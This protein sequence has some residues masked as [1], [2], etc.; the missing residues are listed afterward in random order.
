M[1]PLK[2]IVFT[3]DAI[4]ALVIVGLAV[5]ILAYFNYS[6]QSPYSAGPSVTN[7]TISALS[8]E[9]PATLASADNV[10][11]SI[12]D[13]YNASGE[14]WMQFMGGTSRSAYVAQGPL[15]PTIQYIFSANAP[16]S[17]SILAGYGNIYF[18]AGNTLYAVNASSGTLSWSNTLAYSP[19]GLGL[20]DGMLVYGTTSNTA[21]LSAGNGTAL[22]SSSTPSSKTL[23]YDNKIYTILSGS[24]TESTLDANNGTLSGSTSL[25][26]SAN[27]IL[28][29][30]GSVY[31]WLSSN[32]IVA[33]NQQGG[34]VITSPY[35]SANTN[36]S[37]SDGLLYVGSNAF[38]CAFYLNLTQ[39]FC[40]QMPNAITAVASGGGVAAYENSSG[41]SLLSQS[42]SILWNKKMSS[43]GTS[44]QY[45]IVTNSSVYSVWSNGYVIR[46]NLST[47]AV[48]WSTKLPYQYGQI[49]R[50][51][52]GYGN[53]YVAASGN[54]IAY[55]ACSSQPYSSILQNI[56][57]LYF[58]GRGSCA[59]YLVDK[60][61]SKSNLGVFIN[62]SYAPSF[63]T[64]IFNGA[65]S[66]VNMSTSNMPTGSSSI[67]ASG[68]IYYN[69]P[70]SYD[71]WEAIYLMGSYSQ[72][73]EAGMQIS[74]TNGNV[75]IFDS[76][77]SC[78]FTSS[79]QVPL[80]TWSFVGFSHTGGTTTATLY[81]NGQSQ[82]GS[83]GGCDPNIGSVFNMIGAEPNQH[84]R[85]FFGNIANIQVYSSA[86]NSTQMNELYD[87]GISGGPVSS[88]VVG[89]WPL[90][91]DTND[92]SGYNNTG[93]PIN[94]NYANGN[95]IPQSYQGAS[96][97]SVSSALVPFNRNGGFNGANSL[98]SNNPKLYKVSVYSWK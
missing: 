77:G 66:Y 60:I 74:D 86:L 43:Y 30:N 89:W 35:P 51:S 32:N 56:V 57:Q 36:I 55:G 92:Y 44:L 19:S 72:G 79:L 75:L 67:S 3:T 16:V 31:A 34:T 71:L 10:A 9:T 47:G 38:E 26:S 91:G 1:H 69:G 48:L 90:E 15:L 54:V 64:L 22:W 5:S 37:A 28:E 13:E 49:S 27:E 42:G 73:K 2:G 93:Y 25:G 59:T 46:Q 61:Y 52:S 76:G 65:S 70:N 39:K 4:F 45:P 33:L 94:I 24:Q 21:A 95:Y 7:P 12:L 87:S 78:I 97:I 23:T 40:D 68:W 17:T 82:Q 96:T 81:L 58:E 53:L 41:M 11:Q 83:I 6:I 88:N 80:D 84:T 8:A 29:E 85:Y 14:Q 63:N 20:Y 50:L 62:G 98:Y 18:G